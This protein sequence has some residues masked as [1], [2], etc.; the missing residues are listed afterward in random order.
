MEARIYSDRLG[1]LTLGQVI[2]ECNNI[3]NIRATKILNVVKD[4]NSDVAKVLFW[5]MDVL[6]GVCQ[7]NPEGVTEAI[8]FVYDRL[9]EYVPH[10]KHAYLCVMDDAVVQ[11]VGPDDTTARPAFDIVEGR[12]VRY[13]DCAVSR[14]Y[15]IAKLVNARAA[16]LCT[17]QQQQK[18]GDI[19]TS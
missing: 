8:S 1:K 19:P 2:L 9:S 10:N 12:A 11:I 17:T 14:T 4:Q 7:S 3:S 16:Q 15:V 13:N 18:S 6:Y 5:V